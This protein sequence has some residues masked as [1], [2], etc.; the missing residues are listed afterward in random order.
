MAETQAA[1]VV[2]HEGTTRLLRWLVVAVAIVPVVLFCGAA[3]LNYVEAF[4]AARGR[5]TN[6]TNAI[7]QHAQKVF[8][9]AELILG[10]IAE[11]TDDMDW[12]TIAALPSCTGCCRIWVRGRGSRWSA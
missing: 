7:N 9:T 3:W 6:A 11:R 1:T 5:V 2:R 10:Q 8:E 12:P 4:S